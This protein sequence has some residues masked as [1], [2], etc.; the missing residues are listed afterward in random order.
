VG[1]QADMRD[2]KFQLFEWLPTET[3]LGKEHFA[4]WD[5]E[6]VEMVLQEALKLSR[7]VLAPANVEGD[8]I[9]AQ[10]KDGKVTM[11]AVFHDA[12]QKITEGGWVGCINNPEFGG[13]G[14]P[15][16]VGTA[17][18]E[19]F[20]GANISLSLTALLTR[21][22]SY[23]IERYGTDEM[24]Q[25][26]C[27]R[28]YSGQW[29]GTM[30]LTE[31]QAGSDG[32][33]SK[34][35]AVKQPNGRYLIQGEKIFITS[36]DQDITENIIH[37]VLARTPDA[38]PGTRGL[39][40]FIIPKVRVN[41][42]GSLGEPNDVSC[43]NIEHKLGIHGSP[44][45]TLVFG[46]NDACEGFLLGEEQEG[47]KLMFSMM[48]P[49]RIE[50]GLQGEALAAAAFQAALEYART[51]L[52]GRHWSKLR[53]HD[54]AQVPIV[55]HPDVRRM[56]MTSNAYVQAMR[57]LLLQTSF[58]ID[59]SRNTEGEEQER[60]QSYVDV[61]TPICKAWASDWGFRV[62]EW[63]LQVYGGYGY[64]MEYPAEQYLRD[65][66]IASIYEGTNGIQ[67]LDFVARKLP[68]QGGKP[69]RELLG[70]AEETFKKL[71]S[72]TELMEPAWML[73]AALKQIEDIS[74]GLGKRPD[75][76]MVVMLNAVP[77]LDMVGDV[78]GAHFLLDQ[79]I[80]A[81]EKLHA[82]FAEKGVDA[83]NPDAARAVLEDD[84]EA[85]FY[86]NKVQTAIHYG[87]RVLPGVTAKA[88]AIRAGE[89][90]PMQAVM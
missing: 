34:A 60:Y 85:A 9:G 58:F 62:T 28:M 50:V 7:E 73:G 8:R 59:M 67:A 2:V 3:L 75:A 64:T 6:S 12:Y 72:D 86:H 16:V 35:R 15:E 24:R 31:S 70:M 10:W 37:A 36:G 11:P 4:E 38:E 71:K 32:G 51:R 53:D 68:A 57:A 22:A 33:A 66:K 44:T 69:I 43:S 5:K 46:Q 54:A 55:Q 52:Q 42:D 63:C 20:F 78:L 23:L 1:Y 14:L 26:F 90:G 19:F 48:N 87:Y 88:V 40:L 39:S 13:M 82:I 61:L 30:C 84:A 74:K 76:M 49:A 29:A 25:L 77:L 41:P 47:M 80:T 27:E 18:N 56:L 89:M 21:G 45:C 79:A 83:G 81:R 17:V 65:A